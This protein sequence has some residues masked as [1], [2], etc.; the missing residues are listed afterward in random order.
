M[1]AQPVG[2]GDVEKLAVFRLGKREFAVPVESLGRILPMVAISSLPEAGEAA[3]AGV[4]DVHGSVVPVIDLQQ[5]L[6][7]GSTPFGLYTPI[8]LVQ[9]GERSIALVVSEVIGVVGVPAAG[10]AAPAEIMPE[11][12]S[13]APAVR[14][15]AHVGGGPVVVLDLESLFLPDQI[16]PIWRLIE[17]M[18]V[19]VNQDQCD[20]VSRSTGVQSAGESEKPKR[21]EAEPDAKPRKRKRAAREKQA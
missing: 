12:L 5:H 1:Q 2:D 13:V 9:Q 18:S 10:I 7:M 19:A 17:A 6:G 8:L 15:L 21:L 3:V 11:G 16:E 14:G 4:I 20:E